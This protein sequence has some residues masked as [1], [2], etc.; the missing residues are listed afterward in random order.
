M[1]FCI[2]VLINLETI[3]PLEE[4]L[5]DILLNE[6][7]YEGSG[8]VQGKGIL[9]GT[10]KSAELE[11]SSQMVFTNTILGCQLCRQQRALFRICLLLQVPVFLVCSRFLRLLQLIH[12]FLCG[13]FERH[14]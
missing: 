10:V 13:I 8:V 11:T 3:V 2:S 6:E 12:F 4:N 5:A 14:L 7:M 1:I 9:T